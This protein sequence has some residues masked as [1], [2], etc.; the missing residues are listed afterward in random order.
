[1]KLSTLRNFEAS[2]RRSLKKYDF[3]HFEVCTERG[4]KAGKVADILMNED[5]HC[6]YL[7]VAL[8][9]EMGGKQVLLPYER[10]QADQSTQSISISRLNQAQ[11]SNLETYNSIAP[12]TTGV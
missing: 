2:S 1:M 8:N 6:Q 10:C 12:K 4:E 5:G 3:T 7:V 9:A 11:L